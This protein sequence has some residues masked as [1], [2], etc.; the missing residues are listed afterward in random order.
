MPPM[1][2]EVIKMKKWRIFYWLG[3][4]TTEMF[5]KADSEEDAIT[6]FE[7]LTGRGKDYIINTEEWDE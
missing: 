7:I 3:S 4:M 6:K 5:V 2:G 1:K